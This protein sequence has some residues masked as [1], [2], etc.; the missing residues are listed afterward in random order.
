M[1]VPEDTIFGKIARG[2]IAADIVYE[3]DLCVAF[4]DI[5]PQAPVHVL[6]IPRRPVV[7]IAAEDADPELLGH[8]V[9][10]CAKVAKQLG[11]E[12]SGYRV[13]TNVGPDAGQSVAHLHLHL[14][15]GRHMAWP[16]G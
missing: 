16:P 6:V 4:R 14:L 7:N 13:V 1:A 12:E 5:S 3:D 2:E 15:G 11:I 9:T 10:V 8:L